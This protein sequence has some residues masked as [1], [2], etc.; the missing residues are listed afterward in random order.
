MLC[1]L[2]FFCCYVQYMYVSLCM[3]WFVCSYMYI[4]VC[5]FFYNMEFFFVLSGDNLHCQPLERPYKC[6]VLAHYPESVPWNPFDKEAVGMVRI[7]QTTAVFI[8]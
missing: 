6:K 2:K 7:K 4:Y 8:C 5:V 3:M 1:T